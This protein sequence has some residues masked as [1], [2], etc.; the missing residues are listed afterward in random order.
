MG[1]SVGAT[2]GLAHSRGVGVTNV[3]CQSGNSWYYIPDG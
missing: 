2:S 3:G 1:V